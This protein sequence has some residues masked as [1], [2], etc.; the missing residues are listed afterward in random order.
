MKKIVLIALISIPIL[1][2]ALAFGFLPQKIGVFLTLPAQLV[3]SFRDT[4]HPSWLM[5]SFM[6]LGQFITYFIVA[7]I[8]STL[9]KAMYKSGRS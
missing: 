5:F 2:D 1:I 6:A 4:A 3:A 9:L 7:Y 8:F